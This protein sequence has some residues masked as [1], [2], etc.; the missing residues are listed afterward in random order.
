MVSDIEVERLSTIVHAT[1]LVPNT[2]GIAFDDWSSGFGIV[3]SPDEY[4][5]AV[6]AGL[7]GICKRNPLPSRTHRG[8]QIRSCDECRAHKRMT[9]KDRRKVLG[10]D[11][12]KYRT[13]TD[14]QRRIMLSVVQHPGRTMAV[15][16]ACG[17]D[18]S[19]ATALARVRPLIRRGLLVLRPSPD[20]WSVQGRLPRIAA[21]RRRSARTRRR[22][23]GRPRHQPHPVTPP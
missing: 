4:Q 19:S 17:E 12:R 1:R 6:A 15:V 2:Y 22:S 18:M 14:L 11:G 23:A 10:A 9:R 13:L 5:D 16:G 21:A 7:C 20:R 3:K 8:E